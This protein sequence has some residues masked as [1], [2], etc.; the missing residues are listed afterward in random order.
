MN[1]NRTY[2]GNYLHGRF[3]KVADPIGEISSQNPGDLSV[4][5]LQF[6]FNYEHVHEAIRGAKRSF[7]S[8]KRQSAASRFN[9]LTKYRE[10]LK[11]RADVV[12][13]WISF[14]VGKP[15][16]ESKLEVNNC[17]DLI[18]YYL[19]LG[20]QTSVETKVADVGQESA[21]LIRFFPR[22]VMAI[23]SPSYAPLASPHSHLIPALMNG[24]TVVFKSSKYAPMVGQVIAEAM[25]D[26]G[27]PAGVFNVV[28]GNTEAARR[29]VSDNDVDGVFFTGNHESGLKIQKQAMGS[30][31]KHLVLEMGG[32]N[33]SII[34]EDCDYEMSLSHAL[35]GAYLTTGQRCTTT[36]RFLVH[37]KLFTRFVEDFHQLSK[38][39]AIGYGIAEGEKSPFMGPLISERAVEDYLRYQGIAVREGA[40]EIMRGK[41]LERDKKGYYVSPSIHLVEKHDPKSI[42]QKSDIPGPNVAIYRVGDLDQAIELLNMPQT[43]LVASVYT[44]AKERF[45]QVAEDARVGVLHWNR[46]TTHITYRLPLGGIKDSGNGR[47]MGSFAGYQ[48]TYPMS[49]VESQGSSSILPAELPRLT[50]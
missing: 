33:S 43:G 31:G 37:E 6:P 29:L 8:W 28:H 49:C 25:H 40:E 17:L 47:P 13:Y 30:F 19:K 11:S 2:Q 27:L 10:V 9:A 26:A 34:W 16:W 3:V 32:K 36:C 23:M 15:L 38:K 44:R 41:A 21:G 12:A 18:D 14:E 1:P 22:G 45:Y 20:S 46:P 7:L 5:P 4:A 42:Y 48:C 50:K 35:L 39:A 24:N